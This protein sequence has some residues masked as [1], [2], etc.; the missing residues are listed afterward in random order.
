MDDDDPPAEME[1]F[2]VR[3][4]RE[5]GGEWH[6]KVVRLPERQACFF[7]TWDDMPACIQHLAGWVE[8][9]GSATPDA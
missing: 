1:T 4:W 2:I 8:D 3:V 9:D 6:G 5:A 7:A